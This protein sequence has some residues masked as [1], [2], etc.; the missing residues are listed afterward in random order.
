VLTVLKSGSLNLL[1]NYGP[2]QVCNGIALVYTF[3]YSQGIQHAMG[4]RCIVICGM[5]GS[6]IFCHITS[7]ILESRKTYKDIAQ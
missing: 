7:L 3:V 2:V 4:I 1:E 6:K 5:P